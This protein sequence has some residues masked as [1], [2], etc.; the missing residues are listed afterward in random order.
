VRNI[1][2][3]ALAFG[4]THTCVDKVPVAVPG[5]GIGEGP[6]CDA[7]TIATAYDCYRLD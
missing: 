6:C 5:L 4:N 3:V 1:H 7:L 2:V